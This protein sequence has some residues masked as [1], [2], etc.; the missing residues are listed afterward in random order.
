ML[1]FI[2]KIMGN[3]IKFLALFCLILFMS[4]D[5]ILEEDLTNDT[6]TPITPTE[7]SVVITNLVNFSWQSVDGADNYR[8]QLIQPSQNNMIVLDSLVSNASFQY[9]LDPGMY[10]WRV[11]GENFAYQTAYSFP[12]AF[13]VEASSD[14]SNQ[15]LILNT[16]TD[17]LYTNNT[18]LLFT[19]NELAFA[20][21]YTFELIKNLNGQTTLTQQ[22]GITGTNFSV[23]ASIFD[24]DAAY[25]WKIKAVNAT[26]ETA[27]SSRTVLIDRQAPNQP[28]LVTPAADEVFT[29][30]TID[31]NWTIGQDSGNVQS[32]VESVLEIAQDANF[33]SIV[34]SI[35]ISNGNAQQLTLATTGTYYWRVQ[36]RDVAGNSSAFSISRTF[37]IE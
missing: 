3:N 20:N 5:D 6:V 22:S 7:G 18:N 26:S 8:L 37:T 28:S 35:N 16:P 23:N 24:E 15:S 27:Y 25:I 34:E 32:D 36:S 17:N 1:N 4:C 14:L 30:T 21:S 10:E 11:R 13:T 12:V 33:N 19:W 2:F 31:F 9:P 29:E